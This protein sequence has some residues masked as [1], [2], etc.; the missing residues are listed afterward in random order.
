MLNSRSRVAW[1]ISWMLLRPK[2]AALCT[3]MSS[4]PQAVAASLTMAWVASLSAI[5]TCWKIALPPSASIRRKVPSPCAAVRVAI[6]TTAPSRE[7]DRDGAANAL[8]R[9]G[10]DGD[11]AGE[12]G[13][14][15]NSHGTQAATSTIL[16]LASKPWLAR[17]SCS[18]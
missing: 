8:A 3:I 11:L 5:S 7:G 12:S 10:N 15:A 4:R 2:A 1:S 16:P 9:A 6:T 17:S 13:T 14:Y 18:E